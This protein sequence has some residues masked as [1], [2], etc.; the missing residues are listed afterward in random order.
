MYCK[1]CGEKNESDAVFCSHCGRALEGQPGTQAANAPGKADSG[2]EQPV[3][4]VVEQSN[5]NEPSK[6]NKANGFDIASFVV[7]LVSLI[8]EA[9]VWYAVRIGP[10]NLIGPVVSG[11]LSSLSIRKAREKSGEEKSGIMIERWSEITRNGLA[12]AAFVINSV[13]S[14][15]AFIY[16]IIFCVALL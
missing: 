12:T 1:Y 3:K 7:A 6:P 9:L 2:D 15:L 10:F 14:L 16:M 11:F 4:V 5:T 8:W 13:A